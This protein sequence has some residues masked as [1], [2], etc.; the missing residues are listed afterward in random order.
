MLMEAST[1]NDPRAGGRSLPSGRVWAIFGG[2]A[3]VVLLLGG[4]NGN[5]AW[6]GF[7]DNDTLWDWL[8]LLTLPV[9]IATLPIWLTSREHLSPRVRLAFGVGALVFAVLVLLGY[10]VPWPWTGFGD[11][12][13]WD[14]LRLLL[15]PFVIATVRMWSDIRPRVLKRHVVAVTVLLC[16]LVAV[17]I[18]GYLV[19]WNWTGF[20]GNTLWD[21]IQL[22]AV[23]LLLP[24]VLLPMGVDLIK[25]GVDER[26]EAA[27]AE[28][29]IIEDPD[30]VLHSALT[31]AMVSGP[32]AGL[33]LLE[34]LEEPL[35]DD[36]RFHAT[37]AHLRQ[38]AGDDEK[39][40]ADYRIAAR[41][42]DNPEEQGYL[43]EQAARLRERPA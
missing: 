43:L 15:L 14:W 42:T 18:A 35:A 8:K 34:P 22:V 20:E 30:A 3:L 21:W 37:R 23:P 31:T 11:N 17:V 13:L 19:P 26:R 4:Y 5:W 36:P 24:L 2:I 7:G 16:A 10:L 41:R 12:H 6:T 27:L 25:S 28:Q 1:A 33:A 9:I 32:S 38:M 40:M 29:G 39:A